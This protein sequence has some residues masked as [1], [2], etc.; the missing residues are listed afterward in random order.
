MDFEKL[1]K[2]SEYVEEGIILMGLATVALVA[3][4]ETGRG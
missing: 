1:H 2:W 4:A 3:R